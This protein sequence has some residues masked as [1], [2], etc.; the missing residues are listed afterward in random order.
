MLIK[1]NNNIKPNLSG[2][3]HYIKLDTFH[4]KFTFYSLDERFWVSD[5][6]YFINKKILIL[7]EDWNSI[8]YVSN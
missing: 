4:K 6:Y 8:L 3:R 5:K 2:I 1:D 7:I